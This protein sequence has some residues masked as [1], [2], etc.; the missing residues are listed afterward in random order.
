MIKEFCISKIYKTESV[1]DINENNRDTDIYKKLYV[2]LISESI[3]NKYKR[4]NNCKD[5][6]TEIIVD[7][8]SA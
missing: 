2:K 8:S 7:Y 3:L 6:N 4:H 1:Y 5:P